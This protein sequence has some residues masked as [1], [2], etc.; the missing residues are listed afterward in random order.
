MSPE[1]HLA[2]D[3]VVEHLVLTRRDH[4]SENKEIVLADVIEKFWKER[5]VFV[6]R[7]GYFSRGHIWVI[8]EREDCVSHEWHKRYSLGFTD[9]FG[10]VGCLTTSPTLGCGQAECNWKEFKDNRSGKRS[11]LSPEKAKKLSVIS[12]SYNHKKCEARRVQAQR[13]G[14]IWTDE[15][16]KYCKLDS[17]CSESIIEKLK[18]MK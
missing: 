15:D 5:D 17:Y 12:A 13:A 7:K 1:V 14:V 10:E 6:C 11:N 3:R 4:T 2:V 8:A 18:E 16:F 9:V